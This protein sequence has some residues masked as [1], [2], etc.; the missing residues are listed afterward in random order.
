MEITNRLLALLPDEIP[1]EIASLVRLDS[2]EAATLLRQVIKEADPV[3]DDGAAAVIGAALRPLLG[4]TRGD[5]ETVT[6]I[7]PK[8]SDLYDAISALVIQPA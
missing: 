3:D 6:G 5:T 4:L 8:E 1:G 2:R 7:G